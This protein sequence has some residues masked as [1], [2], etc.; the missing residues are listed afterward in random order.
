MANIPSSTSKRLP[1]IVAIVAGLLGVFMIVNYMRQYEQSIADKYAPK[2]KKTVVQ[3]RK[4][5]PAGTV[6]TEEHIALKKV[7]E[8]Y[9]QP[10]VVTNPERILGRKA[11]VDIAEGEQITMSKLVLVD[12]QATLSK[13]TPEGKRA[14]TIPVDS[15]TSVGGLIRTG[16]SVDVIATIAMPG[17]DAAGNTVTQPTVLPLFQNVLVLAVGTQTS[18]APADPSKQENTSSYGNITLAL[19]P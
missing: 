1:L 10:Y 18:N 4:N 19:G 9:S 17:L 2:E 8:E 11:V 13:K 16:D 6:I 15:L 3:A 5:I 7:P 14:V 12:T